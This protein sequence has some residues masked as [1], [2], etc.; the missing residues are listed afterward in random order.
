VEA[1]KPK[2]RAALGFERHQ[3][4]RH[5]AMTGSIKSGGS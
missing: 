5:L 3:Q 4:S 1:L 2:L